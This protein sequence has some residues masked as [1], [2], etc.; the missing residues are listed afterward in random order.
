MLKDNIVTP[1]EEKIIARIILFYRKWN[2]G[3][4]Q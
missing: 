3:V 2:H 1:S 4:D